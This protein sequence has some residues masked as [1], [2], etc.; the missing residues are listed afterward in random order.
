MTPAAARRVLV[1][2][3]DRDFADSLRNL[4]TLEGYEVATAYSAP[5]AEE[6]IEDFDAQVAI[7]DYRLGQANGLDLV[8][9]LTRRRPELACIIS[10]AYGE[11]DT[12]IQALRHKAYDY[13]Q[14]PLRTEEFMA[15]L[16]RCFDMLRVERDKQAAAREMHRLNEE[17]EARVGERTE[18]LR[19]A[20][21]ELMRKE[22]LAA[23]GQVTATVGH[24]LRGPLATI[25]STLFLLDERLR[26]KDLGVEHALDRLDRSI[27]RCEEIIGDLLDYTRLRQLERIPTS[28][29]SWLGHLLDEESLPADVTLRRDLASGAELAIDRNRLRR[30]VCNVLKNACQAMLDDAPSEVTI[31]R[32]TLTV[33][34]TLKDG[35]V[36]IEVAD[37]GPGIPTDQLR[38]IF[39]P[40]YTT[41]A[42]GVGLG[43]PLVEQVM[44]QHGGGLELSSEEGRGTSAILWLPAQTSR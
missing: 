34:S 18:A 16:E 30:A 37:T 25:R 43:L 36:E 10:T 15:T 8:A 31:D 28:L 26:G 14:K 38:E 40:L 19:A 23:V 5:K 12:A 9:P 21:D 42:Y 44:R 39:Q 2:D 33:T 11:I 17:L 7:L 27:L 1:V 6:V 13:L 22:R 29:D 35:R 24:D 41:K 32:K 3:D 20:Q 4:L